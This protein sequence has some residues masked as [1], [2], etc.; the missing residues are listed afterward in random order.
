MR[1][2][3]LPNVYRETNAKFLAKPGEIIVTDVR[4]FLSS[5]ENIYIS[6]FVPRH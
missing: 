2:Y 1:T 6:K 4:Y 3:V 5:K